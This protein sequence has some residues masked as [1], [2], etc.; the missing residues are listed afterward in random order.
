MFPSSLSGVSSLTTLSF[1]SF[2]NIS[3]VG[4]GTIAGILG[5]VVDPNFV[6]GGGDRDFRRLFFFLSFFV[7]FLWIILRS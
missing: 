6:A 5:I 3:L 7:S 1:K 2:P 4:F